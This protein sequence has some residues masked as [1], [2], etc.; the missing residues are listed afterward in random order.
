MW[1][2]K[3]INAA[4]SGITERQGRGVY[5]FLCNMTHPT[6]YPVRQMTAWQHG[7]EGH[8]ESHLSIDLDFLGRLA[9]AAVVTYF[10]A[11]SLLMGYMGWTSDRFSAW[12]EL[13]DR[14]LP[15]TFLS[16]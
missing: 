15:G 11:I 13:I 2:H 5:G 9:G 4:G 10:N 7:P 3:C 8:L 12:E 6:L 1:M 16:S 14:T